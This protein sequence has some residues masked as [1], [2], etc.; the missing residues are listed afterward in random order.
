MFQE[1]GVNA[2][3]SGNGKI[4]EKIFTS[5]KKNEAN[6]LEGSVRVVRQST[7]E[8]PDFFWDDLSYS[9]LSYSIPIT[10]NNSAQPPRRSLSSSMMI[11]LYRSFSVRAGAE[12]KMK[13][14]LEREFLRKR[15]VVTL[16][17]MNRT[18]TPGYLIKALGLLASSWNPVASFFSGVGDGSGDAD[19]VCIDVLTRLCERTTKGSTQQYLARLFKN[20]CSHSKFREFLREGAYFCPPHGAVLPL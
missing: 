14:N 2:E 13:R 1:L 9:D 7:F 20:L 8:D 6:Y 4:A 15:S 16:D 11:N 5:L 18:D 17:D 19:A 3:S 10:R 12:E